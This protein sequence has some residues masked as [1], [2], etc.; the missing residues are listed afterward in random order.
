MKLQP[1]AR[2]VVID[3]THSKKKLTGFVILK[4]IAICLT[5]RIKLKTKYLKTLV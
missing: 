1:N 3:D 4:S 5:M 2:E